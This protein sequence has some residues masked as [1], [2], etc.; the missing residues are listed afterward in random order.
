MKQKIRTSEIITY[1]NHFNGICTFNLMEA[2][3]QDLF[4][5]IIAAIKKI[6][7]S[8]KNSREKK[9]RLNCRAIC[10]TG[11]IMNEKN[12]FDP[13]QLVCLISDINIHVPYI[14]NISFSPN[15]D[16]TNSENEYLDVT[17]TAKMQKLFF[18]IADDVSITKFKL[19]SFV[20]LKSKYAKA[21]YLLLLADNGSDC[22]TYCASSIELAK[23]IGTENSDYIAQN[24]TK[25][26]RD[27]ASTGDLS[28][29]TF[30]ILHFDNL[31]CD[32]NSPANSNKII[33]NYVWSPERLK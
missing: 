19:E 33:I 26:M 25:I 23:K 9:Y 10:Y 29:A 14:M 28:E 21:I 13:Q 4:F 31:Y 2:K 18:D 11:K 7:S 3:S 27:I 16:I 32:R 24:I 20:T 30:G 12:D 22:G 5:A 6:D 1:D 17:V 8:M 15:S